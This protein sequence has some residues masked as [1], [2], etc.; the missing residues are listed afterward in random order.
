MIHDAVVLFANAARNVI[1][2][3]NHFQQPEFNH[4]DGL[5]DQMELMEQTSWILGPLIVNAIKNVG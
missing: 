2:S 4:I 1:N 3:V 5:C